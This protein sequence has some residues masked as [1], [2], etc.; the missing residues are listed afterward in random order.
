M[1]GVSSYVWD[2]APEISSGCTFCRK[3]RV[4]RSRPFNA[5]YIIGVLVGARGACCSH[6]ARLPRGPGRLV[7]LDLPHGRFTLFAGSGALFA[8]SELAGPEPLAK[9]RPGLKSP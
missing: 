2:C 8:K 9:N 5:G 3:P 1:G 4:S 7:L 6:F